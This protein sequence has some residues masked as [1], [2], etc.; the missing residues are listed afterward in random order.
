MKKSIY[1][2]TA[3][4]VAIGLGFTSCSNE[5]I[6][7]GTYFTANDMCF[8]IISAENQTCE[9][10]YHPDVSYSGAITI[11]GTVTYKGRDFMVT[12]IGDDAFNWATKVTHVIIP[13]SVTTIGVNAFYLCT[14]LTTV[15]FST[16][17]T[18]IGEN[19]FE[20][21]S[22]LTEIILPSSVTNIGSDA[23]RECTNLQFVRMP[24][25]I[26]TISDGTF[27][28]CTE[29]TEVTIPNSVTTIGND[30]FADTGL[31]EVTIPNSVMNIGLYAFKNCS[32]KEMILR[33]NNPPAAQGFPM[34]QYEN[35][36]VYVPKGRL[37][38]Y[39]SD[40]V[41]SRFKNMQ[42]F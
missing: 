24:D 33:P 39:R 22:S 34:W 10:A 28:G 9:I 26:T 3:L 40:N 21:C 15:K 32:L 23:F 13:R 20:G 5:E 27:Y 4:C 35:V 25:N 18:N 2:L 17:V 16:F 14:G 6:F 37:T 29:L 31:T 7:D 30:A 11:P 42:E 41:W 38:A 8:K 36:W 12:K 1:C 19:A